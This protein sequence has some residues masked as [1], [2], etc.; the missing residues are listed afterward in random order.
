MDFSNDISKNIMDFIPDP[1]D[2]DESSYKEFINCI[3][4]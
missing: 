1:L 3:K 4:R 2:V